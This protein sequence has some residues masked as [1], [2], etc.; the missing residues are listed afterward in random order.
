[1][2]NPTKA[3]TAIWFSLELHQ[4]IKV[5]DIQHAFVDEQQQQPRSAQRGRAPPHLRS[6][7]ACP[8][9]D[10]QPTKATERHDRCT[11]HVAS[12]TLIPSMPFVLD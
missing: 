2:P 9:I 6:S 7:A 11:I 10:A 4:H 12:S 8:P 5:L 1:M 3:R